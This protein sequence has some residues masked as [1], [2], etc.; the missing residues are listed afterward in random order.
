MGRRPTIGGQVGEAV[1][2]VVNVVQ[3]IEDLVAAGT[4]EEEGEVDALPTGVQ[5]ETVV[6]GGDAGTQ[7]TLVGVGGSGGG[8][9]QVAVLIVVVEEG[10]AG[11]AFDT[12]EFIAVQVPGGIA[13]L[14]TGHGTVVAYADTGQTVL[15]RGVQVGYLVLQGGEVAGHAVEE[16]ADLVLPADFHLDALVVHVTRVHRGGA[17]AHDRGSGDTRH[18]EVLGPLVEPVQVHG[19]AVAQEAQVKTHVELFGGLPLQFLVAGHRGSVAD[20]VLPGAVGILHAG[21]VL[22]R[23]GDVV[24]VGVAA[25]T[26]D[27][28]VLAPAQTELGEGDHL[29]ETHEE[30]LFGEGPTGGNGREEAPPHGLGKDGEVGGVG[31]EGGLYVILVQVAPANTAEIGIL[32]AEVLH[33]A[34]HALGSGRGGL[35]D[36]VEQRV[37]PLE[38]EVDDT[39]GVGTADTGG[40]TVA[41]ALRE[42]YTG[43]GAQVVLA[44]LVHPV[45]EVLPLVV[46]GIVGTG[47]HGHVILLGVALVVI[48][49]VAVAVAVAG[50]QAVTQTGGQG[51]IPEGLEVDGGGTVDV[52]A[53]GDGVGTVAL[54]QR[55]HVLGDVELGDTVVVAV[56]V[57]EEY[58]AVGQIV[59]HEHRQVVRGVVGGS[60]RVQLQGGEH[61]GAVVGTFG[62]AAGLVVFH[63]VVG[64]H[65]QPGLELPGAV[66]HAGDTVVHVGLALEH[67]V[68]GQ[69]GSGEVEVSAVVAGAE[70]E[71]M[72]VH[73]GILIGFLEPVGVGLLVPLGVDVLQGNVALLHVELDEFLGV[74]HLGGLAQA[75]GRELIAVAD[76]AVAPTLAG[77]DHDHA[78][79]GLGAV[80]GGGGAVLQ[81]FHRFDVVRVDSGDGVGDTAVHNIQRVGIVVGGDTT[82]ADGRGCARTG[83]RGEGLHTG[84]LAAEGLLRRGDGSVLDV[85]G[86]HLGNGARDIGFLLH[87]VTHDDGL[88]D[89]LGVGKHLDVDGF[90]LGGHEFLGDVTH[91]GEFDDRPGRNR[92]GEAAVQIGDGAVGGALLDD[93]GGDHRLVLVVYNDTGNSHP[94]LRGERP[95]HEE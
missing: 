34:T 64:G 50:A 23:A 82:H 7:M 20:D 76:L 3:G 60:H 2:S 83:R 6:V 24:G 75:L 53:L 93:T 74:H 95:S 63:L 56:F 33:A 40:G 14:E 65:F 67:T 46:D 4:G 58:L 10:L 81:H 72:V 90:R 28:T 19:E 47:A 41:A 9:S 21:R 39:V 35:A 43:H 12:G 26:G 44:E 52:E 61:G 11:G 68:V 13:L 70:G 86:L 80:D 51:D 49:V 57:L 30:R 8:A 15:Q 22:T 55:M 54:H 66:H 27:G 18:D 36:V 29:T 1:R 91:G 88:F 17:H 77:G 16:V 42:G 31:T 25:Q 92:E 32:V 62:N 84:G 5:G 71:V 78:V 38:T 89:H 48:V 94:L 45:G 37:V 85:L 59:L 69:V 87:A 79:T 73:Q